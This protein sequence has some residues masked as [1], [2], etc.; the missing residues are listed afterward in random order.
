M[1][2][3][4]SKPICLLMAAATV[5]ALTGA[6]GFAFFAAAP[7]AVAV[8]FAAFAETA[9]APFLAGAPFLRGVGLALVLPACRALESACCGVIR[10]LPSALSVRRRLSICA[11]S[12]LIAAWS[13]ALRPVAAGGFFCAALAGGLP[14]AAPPLLPLTNCPPIGP[15]AARAWPGLPSGLNSSTTRP[16]GKGAAPG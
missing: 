7:L 13:W 8:C 12:A 4:A 9:A 1:I 15:A 16:A 6:P 2:C 14:L 5:L 10:P 3:L 11:R